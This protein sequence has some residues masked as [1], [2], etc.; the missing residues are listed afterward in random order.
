M[1]LVQVSPHDATPVVCKILDYGKFVFEK[2]K[3][4][5]T[6]NLRQKKIPLKK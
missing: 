2:K 6:P 1:D 4:F 3:I 5:Q